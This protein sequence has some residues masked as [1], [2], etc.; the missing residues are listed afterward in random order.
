MGDNV[1]PQMPQVP[2]MPHL[3]AQDGDEQ[4][5]TSLQIRLSMAR[6]EQVFNYVRQSMEFIAAPPQIARVT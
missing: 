4:P 6:M 1:P 2:D 3:A 5:A